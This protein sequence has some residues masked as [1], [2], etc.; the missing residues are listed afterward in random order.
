MLKSQVR[1]FLLSFKGFSWFALSQL[2]FLCAAM[3]YLEKS[4]CSIHLR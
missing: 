3:R 1:D 2:N 4:R